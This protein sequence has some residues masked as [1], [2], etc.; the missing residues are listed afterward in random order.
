MIKV[1]SDDA[2]TVRDARLNDAVELAALAC[3]LGYKTTDVEM[4]TRLETV[5]KDARYKTFVAETGGKLCGMIGTV[6]HSSYLHNDLSGQIIALV[7]S[8]KMRRC[9]IARELVAAAQQDFAWRKIRRVTLT[10]QFEREEAHR[11]Y[12]KLGYARTGFRFGKNLRR[13]AN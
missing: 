7:V 13:T 6:S 9:G 10:T 8:N 11:F 5:L 12:E 2:L 3:E 4:A 1:G